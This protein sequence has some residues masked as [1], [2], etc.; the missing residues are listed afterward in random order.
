M[1]APCDHLSKP[2]RKTGYQSHDILKNARVFNNLTDAV[3]QVDLVVGTTAKKRDGRH[4]Y[5]HPRELKAIIQG[6]ADSLQSVG[7]VF[8]RED[9]GLSNEELDLCDIIST[10]PLNDTYPSLNL[11]HSVMIYAYEIANLHP[12]SLAESGNPGTRAVEELKQA[13]K[14]LVQWLEIEKKTSLKKR[15]MDRLALANSTDI[16]LLLSLWKSL[17]H[18]R[19]RSRMK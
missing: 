4:D 16:H 8:G 11:S 17:K 15:I 18:K 1:V 9:R 5:L 2:A 14:E 10:I 12:D 13:A 6:K 19:G 7:F 3:G